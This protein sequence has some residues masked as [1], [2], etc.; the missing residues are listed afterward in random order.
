MGK[1]RR[2]LTNPKK[3]GIK[4]FEFLDNLDGTDDN[5]I[6]STKVP[7]TLRTLGLVANGDRTVKVSSELYG[8]GSSIANLQLFVLTTGGVNLASP[9][10]SSEE[11]AI[12]SSGSTGFVYSTALPALQ[13]G[14]GNPLVLPKGK[15]KIKA[16]MSGSSSITL[17]ESITIGADS[18]GLTAASLSS[19]LSSTDALTFSTTGGMV[20][21]GT[22]H[23]S[24]SGVG[25]S[26]V[27]SVAPTPGGPGHGFVLSAS[28]SLTGS[29]VLSDHAGTATTA[30]GNASTTVTILQSSSVAALDEQTLTVTLTPLDVNGAESTTEAISTTLT[31]PFA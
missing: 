18:I 19:S 8:S 1:K 26:Q 15:V 16:V 12:G 25:S 5:V 2:I 24:G 11:P 10:T 6:S 31:V 30:N 27:Y 9:V 13:D 20:G 17:T 29:L 3:F 4:H 21:T 23:G 14:S 22:Q 7:A 28:G